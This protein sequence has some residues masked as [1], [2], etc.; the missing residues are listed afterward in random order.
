[1]ESQF[2]PAVIKAV[3]KGT[4]VRMETLDPLGSNIRLS[5]D[6]YVEFLTALSNQFKSCLLD[7]N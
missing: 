3:I 7:K 5:K 2:K 6:S 4:N 1:A